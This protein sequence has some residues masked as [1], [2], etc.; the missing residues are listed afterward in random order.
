MVPIALKSLALRVARRADFETMRKR[1]PVNCIN[2]VIALADSTIIVQVLLETG[3]LILDGKVA[4][5]VPS[6]HDLTLKMVADVY[7]WSLLIPTEIHVTDLQTGTLGTVNKNGSL[8][9][10][11]VPTLAEMDS[12]YD[13]ELTEEVMLHATGKAEESPAPTFTGKNEGLSV[14]LNAK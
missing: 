13:E 10:N 4:D 3:V 9:A 7:H 11:Y 2:G 8:T 5:S 12:V 14:N 6:Y 1:I